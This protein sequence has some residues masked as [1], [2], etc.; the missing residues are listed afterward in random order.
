MKARTICLMIMF[1]IVPAAVPRAFAAV[2]N[3]TH[4]AYYAS[5]T[6]AVNAALSGDQLLVSTG[7]Y[8]ENI[9]LAG[10]GLSIAGGYSASFQT[11]TNNAQLTVVQGAAFGPVCSIGTG[12]GLILDG[13][14]ITGGTAFGGGGVWVGP[15]CAFTG[16]FCRIERNTALSGG[17]LWVSTN[18]SVVLSNAYVGQNNAGWG[19]GIVAGAQS[20][21]VLRGPTTLVAYNAAALDGGGVA[22]YNGSVLVEGGAWVAA[23]V[24]AN[25]GGGLFVSSNATLVV[26]DAN[27]VVGGYWLFYNAAT[28]GSGGGIYADRSAILVSGTACRVGHNAAAFDGGGIFL[29][30]STLAVMDGAEIGGPALMWNIAFRNGGGIYAHN[31]A[32]LIT[33]NAAVNSGHAS[34]TGGG[35]FAENSSVRMCDATLGDTNTAEANYATNAAGIFTMNCT[36][37]FTRTRILNNTAYDIGGGLA[38]VATGQWQITDCLIAGNSASNNM[39]GGIVAAMSA[40]AFTISHSDIVSNRAATGGGIYWSVSRP[41][42]LIDNASRIA[43]NTAQRGAGLWVVTMSSVTVRNSEISYNLADDYGG[44][45]FVG[46]VAT[47]DLDGTRVLGN[48]G[49]NDHDGVGNGGGLCLGGPGRV[50]AF[51]GSTIVSNSA[52]NGG[53]VALINGGW[54]DARGLPSNGVVIGANTATNGGGLYLDLDAVALLTGDVTLDGNSASVGGG[55]YVGTNSVLLTQPTNGVGALLVNNVASLSGGGLL[56]NGPN[57]FAET[58]QARFGIPGG[59]NVA[60]GTFLAGG[61][62]G[63]FVINGGEY[64]A[65]NCIFDSNVASNFGGAISTF[66]N[67]KRVLVDSEFSAPQG[68]LPLTR[69]VNNRAKFAGAI[70]GFGVTD[71]QLANALIASNCA[72]ELGGALVFGESWTGSVVNVIMTAN[73]ASNADAVLLGDF[74]VA[75]FQHCTIADNN[76]NGVVHSGGVGVPLF[77]NCIVW[78][79]VV[80]QIDTNATVRFCDVQGGFTGLLNISNNPA[81]VNPAAL[82]Y[83]LAFDSPCIDQ[84]ATLIAVTND[85]IGNP[86]PYDGGWDMGAYEFVPEP[87]ALLGVLV[88]A[89]MAYYKQRITAG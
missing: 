84:G 2:T 6:S 36:G 59:G 79:H 35:I 5:I 10:K 76:S 62:G 61:G 77:E 55:C 75:T 69:F 88:L 31:S 32:V 3:V 86:R 30:N 89:W 72:S 44:G 34:D 40:G 48:C 8:I 63:V 1:I 49:D 19:G 68:T 50:R 45:A 15:S 26:K 24:A 54:F 81:F 18:A 80:Q 83:Q 4:P 46:N 41:P 28:N 25:R 74:G 9:V 42:L 7:L 66:S 65:F 29:S 39:G 78:G 38:H 21:V 58:R 43:C 70:M 51:N 60:R 22:S 85:C 14:S 37:I 53:G 27:T 82:D 87:G 57:A 47:L 20:R 71:L 23:N 73:S 33:N 52:V 17:G 64:R 67:A 16:L 11:R 12:G 13:L 56:L